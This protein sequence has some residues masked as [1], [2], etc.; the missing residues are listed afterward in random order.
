MVGCAGKK[1]I[2]FISSHPRYASGYQ[3]AEDGNGGLENKGLVGDALYTFYHQNSGLPFF[4]AA[5][6]CWYYV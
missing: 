1:W 4:V 3:R 5:I 2:G 6:H